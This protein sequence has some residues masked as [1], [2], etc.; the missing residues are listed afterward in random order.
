MPDQQNAYLKAMGIDIWVERTPS[1]PA[2]NIPLAEPEQSV[3]E[4]I[5]ETG[6]AINVDL[7]DWQ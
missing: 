7:L 4:L 1:L 3:S 5:T 6:M 2:E